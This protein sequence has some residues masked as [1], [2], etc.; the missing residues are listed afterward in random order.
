MKCS[1]WCGLVVTVSVTCS[2]FASDIVINEVMYHPSSENVREEYIELHNTGPNPVPLRG[3]RISKGV[4]FAIT[5]DISLAPSA[6]LVIAADEAVFRAKYPAI[7]NVIG[8]WTG[9]LANGGEEIEI[10]DVL[11]EN[12][13][14]VVYA[15]EGD[16][17]IRQ[18]GPLFNNGHRGWVWRADHDGLGRSLELVNPLVSNNSGQNWLPSSV[19]NGTPGQ[20]N[21]VLQAD[22]AP[23]I[24][25]VRH[26]PAVPTSS[27]AVTIT[28]AVSDEAASGL[29]VI[30]AQR[31]ASSPNPLAFA[32]T[33]M[34][35]DG[36]H[37]DGLPGDGI[38][39]VVLP[40][41]PHL[42]V[43]EFYVQ[44]TD[45]QANRRTWP[46]AAQQVDGSFAQ[47]A[48]ALFQADDGV[49]GGAQPVVKLVMTESERAELE[50]FS[51]RQT[52][53][54]M[55]ATMVHRD[56]NGT[57]LRYNCGLRIR[58]A[59]SRQR[60]VP[61]FRLNIPSDRRWKDVD[62]VNLNAQ[63]AYLQ[64][65]GSAV[66]QRAGLPAANS[67]AV[68]V[69]VNARNL[70]SGNAPYYGSYAL[71][72]VINGDYADNHYPG[73]PG[74]NLY[75]GSTGQHSARLSYL[76]TN[77]QSYINAGYIKA[78][79]S[80]ENDWTDLFQLTQVLS[81]APDETY[82]EQVADVA[83]VEMWMRYF[84]VFTLLQSMETS[85]GTGRGDDY[86]MYRGELNP[87]FILLPHDLDTIF[88]GG[89]T[90]TPPTATHIFR[91]VPAAGVPGPGAQAHVTN[92][93]R[94]MLHPEFVPIYF[95]ELK[96]MAETAFSP[97]ELNPLVDQLLGSF[98]P[99]TTLA[100][101]KDF[102]V[103][104]N[105][106][107]LGQ[108]PLTLSANSPLTTIVNGFPRTTAGFA[109]VTGAVN[110][111]ET[112]SV[113]VNGALATLTAWQGTWGVTN[114][115][116]RPGINRLLVQAFGVGSVEVGRTTVDIWYDDG[117]VVNVS[118]TL[119]A[120]T[121]WI[122][123]QGPYVVTSTLTV[124]A[125]RTLNIQAGTTVFLAAGANLIVANGGR[126]MAQ[127]TETA[128]IRFTRVPGGGNWGGITVNGGSGSPET[129]IS[130]A[131]IEGNNG[132]AVWAVDGTVAL[133]HLTFGNT[134]RQYVSLDRASFV[135]H[136][137]VFP[138][139]TATFEMIHGSGGIKAGG[140]GVITRSFFGAPIGYNDTI[141]F[142]GGNRPGPILH[143]IDNVFVGSDDD[144]LDLDST[145]AWVEGNIFM[146]VHRNG[147]PDSASAVSGGTDNADISQI[148]IVGNIF[149]D[150]DHAALAKQGNFYTMLNNTVVRQTRAGGVDTDSAVITMADEGTV[151]GAG[152]YLEGN[153]IY[154]AE[155]LVRD[156]VNS[157]V[158]FSNNLVQLAWPGPGGGNFDAD[159]RFKYVPDLNETTSFAT[160][161]QAQIFKEW[162]SLRSGSPAAGA[163]RNGRD[164]GGVIPLGVSISGEPAGTTRSD[165]ATLRVGTSV[166]APG[167]PSG[168]G[169]TH[170]QW[171]LNNG[172]WSAE[173]PINTPIVLD[174]LGDGAH[175]VEVI[176]RRDSGL[177]Q[178]DLAFGPAAVVARS[179]TWTV[180][181]ALSGSLVINEVLA[182][183]TSGADLIELHNGALGEIEMSGMGLTDDLLD[184]FKFKFAVDTFIGPGEYMLLLADD[185]SLGFAINQ[186]GGGLY[187]YSN[188]GLLIDSVEFGPQAPDLSIGRDATGAW[189]LT[190]PTFGFPNEPS[191]L[192][193]VSALR[194]NE[195]LAAGAALFPE[196]F[197][198][199]YNSDALPV[200]LSGLF[201]SDEPAATP[202]YYT[203][204]PLS[205]IGA[206]GHLALLADGNELPFRLAAEQGSIAVSSIDGIIDYICYTPQTTGLAEGRRPSG[207]A[208]I[209][210]F[211][212]T[213]GA[214]NPGTGGD[215]VVTNIVIGLLPLTNVWRYEASSIDLGTA[216]RAPD[217]DDSSWQSG[218]ALLY[219]ESNLAIPFRNTFLPFTS[220]QQT[221]FYFRTTFMVE[222][223][224]DGYFL[225]APAFLDD[226]AV[227]YLNGSEALRVRMPPG[228]ISYTT[229]ATASP[230]DGDASLETLTLSSD[231]LVPGLNVLAVEVHQQLPNSSDIVWGMALEAQLPVT[232]VIAAFAVLSEVMSNNRSVTNADGTITDWVEIYNPASITLDLS[233]QSLTDDIANAR[234]W[235]FPA[236]TTLAPREYLIILFDP[237]APPS[238]NFGSV[239]N[240]GFGLDA[241][242]DEV[243]LFDTPARLGTLIDSVIFGLQVSDYSIGR[244]PGWNLSLPTPGSANIAAQLATVS[245]VRIN[246]WMAAPN[247]G[248]D[249]FEL[250]NSSAQ[251]VALGGL[252]LTDDLNDRDKSLIPPLSFISHST[253]GFAQFFADENP[254]NGPDHVDFRL[255]SGGEW[256]GLLT[257]GGQVIHAIE[258]DNQATGV[259]EGSLPDG[260]T[261]IVRFP[262]TQSPAESNFLPLDHVA[263]N[264]ALTHTDLPLEDAIELH[265]TS[266]AT[267]DIGGW[268]LS[269]RN[270]DLQIFR[271]PQDTLIP[272]GGFVVFHESDFNPA[273]GFL[274]GFALS[275]SGGDQIYLSQADTAGQLTGYRALVNFGAA[276]NGVS[277]GRHETSV[278]F[279]FTS[280]TTRTLGDSNSPPRVGPIVVTEIMYHPP[281]INGTNDN[282]VDEFLELQNIS[283]A[284]V[285]LAG[286]RMRDAVDFNFPSNSTLPPGSY[287]L[288]VSFDPVG[289]PAALAAF[290]SKYSVA[291]VVPVLG[292]YRGKLDNSGESVE[293]VKPDAPAP[294]G[295]V[296]SVLVDKVR[297]RDTTPWASE[298]D[299]GQASLQRRSPSAYGNDPVNWLA[300]LPT[301]GGAT[302]EPLFPYPEIL[303]EPTGDTV[304]P[305]VPA[306]LYAE[307]QGAEPMTYQ[308]RR[309]GK[310]VP[311]ATE[312]F[313]IIPET[314]AAHAGTYRLRVSNPFGT[315]L[316][317]PAT[318]RLAA[319]PAILR[320]PQTRIVAA[321]SSTVL[322]VQAGGTP[323]LRYRWQFGTTDIPGA[324]TFQL[325]L[326]NIQPSQQGTYRVIIENDYGTVTSDPATLT[327][328]D[329]PAITEHP[330][331]ATVLAGA[332]VTL[333]SAAAGTEPLTYQWRVNGANIPGAN[334]PTLLLQDLQ[335]AQSGRYTVRVSNGVGSAISE[336]AIINVLV[337]PSVNIVATDGAAS[338]TGANTGTF[339][340]T[341][342]GA[343]NFN[344]TVNLTRSGSATPGA[345]FTAVPASVFIA[346]GETMISLTVTPIDDSTREATESVMLQ[347]AAGTGYSVGVPNTATVAIADN[348]NALPTVA[349][350][351]PPQLTLYPITPTN[352]QFTVNAADADGT[353]QRVDYYNDGTNHLG[354]ATS[355]PFSF[356]WNNALPG[357]NRITAVATDDLGATA[358]SGL[359]TFFVNTPPK[360][361]ITTPPD[362][363][364]FAPGSDIGL[365]ASASDADGSIV[366]VEFFEGATS[367]G[368]VSTA[369]YSLTFTNAQ[370]GNYVF[371]AVATD[372]RG[373]SSASLPVNVAVRQPNNNFA[374][375]FADRGQIFGYVNTVSGSNTSATREPDEPRAYSGSTRTVWL[376]W[377]APASGTCVIT[378][379]GSS[380]DTVLAVFTNNPPHVES[381]SNLGFV[382]ENDDSGNLQS[383]VEFLALEDVPYQIRVEGFGGDSGNIILTQTLATRAPRITQ[384]PEDVLT[385][386]NFTADFSFAATATM[387]F[388]NQWRFNGTNLPGATGFSLVISNVNPGMEGEYT[389]LVGNA[390]GLDISR[391]ARLEL[392]SRPL[393]VVEPT[394]QTVLEGQP[395]T[396]NVTV[397][398]SLPMSYR[399]RR[400]ANYI[401]EYTTNSLHGFLHFPSAHLTNAATYAVAVTNRLGNAVRLSIPAALTVLADSDRD[402]MPNNWETLY[403]FNT[404]SAADAQLDSDGDTMQNWKEYVAGTHPLDPSSYLKVH[405]FEAS[406]GQATVTF[407]AVSNRAYTV[408]FTDALG[409]PWSS[410]QPVVSRTTNRV[411][412]VID[413]AAPNPGRFYRLAI[414]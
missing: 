152:F 131:H 85:L 249:W 73:D 261:N 76:G 40:A 35:D 136:D 321:G 198:E 265:N 31:D 342:V 262:E 397:A 222:T 10:E 341:R 70:V 112:R 248:D 358:S 13:D 164:L 319:G 135:I 93:N 116:L 17:A 298:A 213:P 27:D 38:Y 333:D 142:T 173:T 256:I 205:F 133:D 302:G 245:G 326:T 97:G 86:A 141:D 69:R 242:G 411:V 218:P 158:T 273:P 163:G 194:V 68:Q 223:N 62:E 29:T 1:I 41:Q 346:A 170:Y 190:H 331:G 109:V 405:R 359:L 50:M 65:L 165:T 60:P 387:P 294:D 74:G 32:P 63:F 99:A 374:D 322:N 308:W 362:G 311:G 204:G 220:P 390:F 67:R 25:E 391:P 360:V 239:L 377:V 300:G 254:Q 177:Y 260:T 9:V 310:D 271:V 230:P 151:E 172:S 193:D 12:V 286:W 325:V 11:G 259:S 371:Q 228:E 200:A 338:E 43:T 49:Y 304:S 392:G 146:H 64:V 238:T 162:F 368:S 166:A 347:V 36:Q 324:T 396:F 117:S 84:A 199:L 103:A 124:P 129:V 313:L 134:A 316:S 380:F 369:P 401:H 349:I 266:D 22:I 394:P 211:A 45:G 125:G 275:S 79:N 317:A 88:G 83:N 57:E 345:D 378:T 71:M 293:L 376:R 130:Y 295:D 58:G 118:G 221:T 413:P 54:Q 75:R 232:N 26:F 123:N 104:R 306:T 81:H 189:A 267:I 398:G 375:M 404:N 355:A 352:V 344:L 16:W 257:S 225:R 253:N 335:P 167:F 28:A 408:E 156:Q 209:D 290:R 101:I 14:S 385:L 39:G 160:W 285:G 127:G 90:P 140:R 206:R 47:T 102:A 18:R 234:R 174:G 178:D 289:D 350:T 87:R 105:A 191:L 241:N 296:P 175:Y 202:R 383:R 309:D 251:P 72:E 212:P 207:A 258:F 169:Y 122:P 138:R 94:F 235:V 276:E 34:F 183:N 312:P 332:S 320:Q 382:V 219:N 402:G 279:D 66:A 250:F 53:A 55:N 89:D 281:D 46:A 323:A 409:M 176:G 236:G 372:D 217:Y 37:N 115:P 185:E 400:G 406:A 42:T 216:W 240:T 33:P 154:D 330:V 82:A 7:T 244:V 231:A 307:A 366:R 24:S 274:P 77:P 284:S 229:L 263:I 395:A 301:A 292:P 179:R 403:G 96:R 52:D 157:V 121:T 277:F 414:P 357:T 139:P 354:E 365:R 247:S 353:V 407:N 188:E 334:S 95:G 272:A 137:C 379:S 288:L 373:M 282:V 339:Q 356:T 100:G 280:V 30:L 196:D 61:N 287:L 327:I 15:S 8:G 203:F 412:S 255:G 21:S 143:V 5:N 108:V 51:I 399:W 98:V 297:Y 187:L 19:L 107:V 111:I 343:T 214:P 237:D 367:L 119:G 144:I 180:N 210:R 2:S 393:L 370:L 197:V 147:S 215:V 303:T 113:R 201:L 336:E 80:S 91:M 78:S 246:E 171:R 110:A 114:V 329:P 224:L 145:D 192:G 389:V 48:N 6:Y 59:G 168:S 92:L 268:F 44:A 195:W 148:T 252:Y 388:T 386:S 150:C 106:H 153:I 233:N 161:R 23:I 149:Y 128:P 270:D 328:Q 186:R 208:L 4:D 381:V 363:E 20:A 314:Q 305:G 340:V 159:P 278:G 299:L 3:W 182:R 269:D 337:P 184:P 410:L 120:D 126:I 264:E 243:F 384:H 348:D 283:G 181:S 132:I 155:K 226:G 351:S 291:P 56:G 318:L 364:A 315:A 361:A 227:I